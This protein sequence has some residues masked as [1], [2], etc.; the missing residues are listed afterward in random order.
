MMS[1]LRKH[2]PTTGNSIIFSHRNRD[3]FVYTC[4]GDVAS[5][6]AVDEIRLT[7]NS[8]LLYADGQLV[9]SFSR[10][11]LCFASESLIEPFQN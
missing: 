2:S 6:E 9:A 5:V 10:S 7:N 3:Y 4:T 11:E 1:S 8:L